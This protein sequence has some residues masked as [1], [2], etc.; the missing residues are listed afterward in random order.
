MTKRTG[1]SPQSAREVW[2]LVLIL[3]MAWCGLVWT[4]HGLAAL[5]AGQAL[6]VG[7][8]GGVAILAA[9]AACAWRWRRR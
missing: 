2:A 3:L 4:M 6:A 8:A 7:L 9:G 1:L 5:S